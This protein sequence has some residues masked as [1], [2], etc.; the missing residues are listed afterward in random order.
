[1]RWHRASVPTILLQAAW[2]TVIGLKLAGVIGWS[3]WWILLPIWGGLALAILK[4]GALI[5][6]FAWSRV[7]TRRMKRGLPVRLRRKMN[8]EMLRFVAE[9]SPEGGIGFVWRGGR[10]LRVVRFWRGSGPGAYQ[11][12]KS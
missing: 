5:G 4:A 3:W 7:L 1:V 2:F 8:S 11:R 12:E 10:R 6:L 9:G